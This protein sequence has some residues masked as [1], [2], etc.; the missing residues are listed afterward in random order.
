MVVGDFVD[1]TSKWHGVAMLLDLVFP[2]LHVGHFPLGVSH[3]R[4]ARAQETEAI[5]NDLL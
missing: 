4:S 1:L 3:V 5:N 2:K